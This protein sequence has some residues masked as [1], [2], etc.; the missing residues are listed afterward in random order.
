MIKLLIFII[1]IAIPAKVFSAQTWQIVTENYPP[2]FS[3]NL[4]NNG[5]LYEVAE[6]ALKTQGI[7]SEVEFTTWA[8]ALKLLEKNRKT[9]ILGAF[10]SLKRSNIF[11]YSRPLAVAHSG[12]FKRKESAIN[13]DG[14]VES[15]TPYSIGVEDNAVVSQEF[16][17]NT[18]LAI[19]S[20]KSLPTSLYLLQQGR[21]DLV[22]GTKEV[23]NYWLK[24]SKTKDSDDDEIEY[25][26]P[27]LASHKLY[28]VVSKSNYRA[29]DYLQKFNRGINIII[30]N[31]HITKIMKK[32][33]FSNE[34]T[35]KYIN[36]L[37]K[38]EDI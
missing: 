24:H 15:L 34:D 18:D 8:R 33:N 9:A 37:K 27:D 3:E 25:L 16:A 28:L 35:T 20:T 4:P 19:S 21:I 5:W 12:I 29:K 1:V 23:G 38:N 17:R 11:Y 32:H 36:F 22:A 6:S 30:K 31:G 2:Y 10:Y 14:T 7:N 26:S 13:F